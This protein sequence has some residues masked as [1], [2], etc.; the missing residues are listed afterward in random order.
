MRKLFST[1]LHSMGLGLWSEQK[2]GMG[3]L[4]LSSIVSVGNFEPKNIQE[5]LILLPF[6]PLYLL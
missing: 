3:L 1:K 4:V 6:Q 5:L 2:E